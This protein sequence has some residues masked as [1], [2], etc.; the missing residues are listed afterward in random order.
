MYGQTKINVCRSI[1]TLF[2]PRDKR[3]DAG[4]VVRTQYHMIG[5]SGVFCMMTTA[6]LQEGTMLFKN[7]PLVG[8]LLEN[9]KTGKRKN[10]L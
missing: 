6:L 5:V 4:R 10:K 2:A 8:V 7:T 1:S 9:L 3:K